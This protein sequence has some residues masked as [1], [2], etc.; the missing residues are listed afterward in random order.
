MFVTRILN[1]AVSTLTSDSAHPYSGHS[2]RG[3]AYKPG[4][5]ARQSCHRKTM[6]IYH[7]VLCIFKT[8]G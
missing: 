5:A 4:L 7:I 8:G 6:F 3:V 2:L 1:P